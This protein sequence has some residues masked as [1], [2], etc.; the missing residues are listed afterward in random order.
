VAGSI[1]KKSFKDEEDHTP[2]KAKTRMSTYQEF[3]FKRGGKP[4]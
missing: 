4:R 2:A 3:D 1:L